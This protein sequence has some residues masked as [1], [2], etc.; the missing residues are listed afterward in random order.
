MLDDGTML[1]DIWIIIWRNRQKVLLPVRIKQRTLSAYPCS[2]T[3]EF[4][5]VLSWH[6][7][8]DNK[9]IKGKDFFQGD[10]PSSLS[11]RKHKRPV[12]TAALS[13]YAV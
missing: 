10:F 7:G 2:S 11:V 8:T 5:K 4:W 12:I 6:V 13:R 3:G 9:A 1:F